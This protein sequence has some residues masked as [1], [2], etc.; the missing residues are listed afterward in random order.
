MSNEKEPAHSLFG[1]SS[2]YRWS[3]CPASVR[4]CKDLP[5]E[6]SEYAKE[7]TM[8]HEIAAALLQNQPMP[9]E[10]LGKQLPEDM[11]P[12]VNEYVELIKK[13]WEEDKDEGDMLLIEHRF[14]LKQIH[15][16]AF[17]TGDAVMY[18]HKKRLLKIFDYK[19]G[20]GYVVSVRNNS[21]LRYYGLG[22]LL[23]LP[24][25][26]PTSVESIIVQPRANHSEGAIRRETY[27][28]MELLDFAGDLSN[29]IKAT[30]DPN[31]PLVSG[32][33][34]RFCVAK[35]HCPALQKQA[36]E[37]AAQEFNPERALET[38]IYDAAKL[39]RL[40]STFEQ[41]E[42][43]I[44]SVREFAFRE[45]ERGKHITGYKLV[46]KRAQRKWTDVAAVS[47]RLAHRFNQSI[48]RECFTAPELKSPAQIE[49]LV[50]KHV[51]NE[52]LADLVSSVSSGNAL[53]NEDDPRPPVS[54]SM[55]FDVIT[56]SNQNLLEQPNNK[57]VRG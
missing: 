40:L 13:E 19:H 12:A 55:G 4:M 9:K 17:G 39:G 54:T 3:K 46:A 38:G 41:V 2:L 22:A 36:L 44:A 56:Q 28:V 21:Q 10:L 57:P 51:F 35:P 49:K 43:Y 23:S 29:F 8:A 25:L 48:T 30:Q 7:G 14:H 16:D 33:H 34:C 26:K 53:A 45:L 24:Q 18:K 15:P 5:N 32:E 37:V 47:Q 1:A 52:H 42:A 31:A 6:S 11:M 20:A 50:N 27:P